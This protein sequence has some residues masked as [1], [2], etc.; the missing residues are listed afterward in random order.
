MR[1]RRIV[2]GRY[3][4]GA[5]FLIGFILGAAGAGLAVAVVAFLLS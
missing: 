3:V 2:I 1:A 5:R 4:F